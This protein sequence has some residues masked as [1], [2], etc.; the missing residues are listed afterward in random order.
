MADD[1]TSVHNPHD[2]FF[3]SLMHNRETAIAFL[4]EFLPD[5]VK[6][7][8]DLQSLELANTTFLTDEL[9][10]YFSDIVFKLK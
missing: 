7:V 3:K 5:E 9:K 1:N 2:R 4:E 6:E 8:L 10:Q